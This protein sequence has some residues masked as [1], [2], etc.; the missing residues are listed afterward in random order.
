VCGGDDRFVVDL[1]KQR[2]RCRGCKK[3]GKVIDLVMH[4]EDCGFPIAV[5][6]LIGERR[7]TPVKHAPSSPPAETDEEA[8]RKALKTWAEASSELGPLAL[9]YL[10]RPRA[11]GGRGL[12]IP[13]GVVGR[14]LR[15]HPRHWWL[16]RKGADPVQVP[17]LIALYRDIETDE[18]RAIWRRALTPDACALGP[19]K[20]RG[21]QAG[22]AI[23]LTEHADVEQGLAVGEGVETMLAAMMH[24]Y[25]PAWALGNRGEVEDFPV[26]AG[27]DALTICVD[28]DESGDGQWSA[29]VCYDRWRAAGREVWCVKSDKVGADLNDE[30]GGEP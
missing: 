27:I 4:I 12:V 8:T 2:F 26:L 9:S 16:L 1:L 28:N 24:G 10:T 21:P 11:Q 23:K 6:K 3:F 17:A 19:A 14:V 25:A 5:A 30:I 29:A 15:F 20:S 22:C 7:F 18:P 13:A